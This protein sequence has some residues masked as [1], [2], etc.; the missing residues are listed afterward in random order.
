MK[1]FVKGETLNERENI[2]K[3]K[4]IIKRVRFNLDETK[5]NDDKDLKQKNLS[6]M[7]YRR[8]ILYTK[9]MFLFDYGMPLQNLNDIL[10]K[11]ISIKMDNEY[12]SITLQQLNQTNNNNNNTNDNNS[13]LTQNN[14]DTNNVDEPPK[15]KR[16]LNN[17]DT[18]SSANIILPSNNDNILNND[19]HSNK[20]ENALNEVSTIKQKES[21]AIMKYNPITQ[22]KELIKIADNALYKKPEWHAPWKLY[23]VISGHKGWVKCVDVDPS[24]EF[25][26][27]GSQ[28][29]TIKIWNLFTGQ[30]KLTLTGHIH[31]VRGVIISKKHPYMFSCGEDKKLVCWDLEQN[32][33]IR[34][35]HGHLSG[36]Y[37]IKL[38]PELNIL[39][40]GGRDSAIRIWDIRTKKQINVLSGHKHT[41]NSIESQIFEPQLI[42]G[43][44]DKTIKTWDLRTMKCMTTLTNHKKAIRSLCINSNNEYTY[45]SAAADNVKVWKC[46]QSIFLRN[47][48]KRPNSIIETIKMNQD[49]I[50]VTGH[51]NGILKFWDYKSGYNY[52]TINIKPQPGSLQSENGVNQ[53]TFDVTGM[54]LITVET[55]KTIKMWKPD[56]NATELSHPIN[57][58]PSKRTRF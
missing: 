25:F 27:T 47:F 9:N 31:T 12:D 10:K 1:G 17:N 18:N 39:F 30:C 43:S 58:K 15:K 29:R 50:V 23:K 40:S 37:C 16:K 52:Q 56:K 54:R 21:K 19:N 24:N 20:I 4:K 33:V 48:N 14:N 35:Y 5:T 36:I 51:Q 7:A 28:D 3:K 53:C 22:T 41:I 13:I 11:T 57:F 34:N 44:H 55:D 6:E 8:S 45:L 2:P 42:S 26:V 38:H 49:N 32:K 46:P